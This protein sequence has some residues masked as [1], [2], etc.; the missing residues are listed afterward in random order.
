MALPSTLKMYLKAK[1]ETQIVHH[2]KNMIFKK[3]SKEKPKSN[4]IL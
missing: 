1:E 4:K 3:S 2:A